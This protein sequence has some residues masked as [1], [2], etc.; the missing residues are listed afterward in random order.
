MAKYSER[1]E[2]RILQIAAE[3]LLVAEYA[4]TQPN[5]NQDFALS[6]IRTAIAELKIAYKEKTQ[7]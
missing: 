6:T 7:V 3:A 4:L 1:P 5:S 2:V